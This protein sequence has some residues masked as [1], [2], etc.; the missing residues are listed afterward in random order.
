[1][2]GSYR[3]DHTGKTPNGPQNNVNPEVCPSKGTERGLD[4]NISSPVWHPVSGDDV[5]LVRRQLMFNTDR[6]IPPTAG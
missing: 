6:R 1:M 3:V 4:K 2:R 5:R